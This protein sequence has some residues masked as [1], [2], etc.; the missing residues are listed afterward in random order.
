MRRLRCAPVALLQLVLAGCYTLQPPR[1]PEPQSGTVL[2]FD[3]ND[4]G[5]TGL[6]GT[7]GPDL[8]RVEGELIEKDTTG[9]LLAV[10][11]VKLRNGGSQVWSGERVRIRS[12]FFYSMYE[13]KFSMGRT[14]AL[15]ALAV[16]GLAAVILTTS[17]LVGGSG[18]G[19]NNGPCP[20][21]CPDARIGRP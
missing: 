2:G 5:R 15:G 4:A 6:S 1:S 3:I 20:P 8:A 18:T 14:I 16:G 12:D 17:L 21:D 13:R 9:Y 11:N 7:M 19:D 10:R